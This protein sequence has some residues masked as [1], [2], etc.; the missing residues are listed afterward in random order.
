VALTLRFAKVREFELPHL[1]SAA[2]IILRTLNTTHARNPYIQEARLE[3][4]L[5]NL[6][7]S[8]KKGYR[9]LEKTTSQSTI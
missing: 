2:L 4:Q 3:E 7:S 6:Q 1:F 9:S 5:L 8:L